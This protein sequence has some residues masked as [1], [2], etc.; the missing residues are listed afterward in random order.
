LNLRFSDRARS[1][2]RIIDELPD[3]LYQKLTDGRKLTFRSLPDP[4]DEPEDERSDTFF[5][6]LEAARRSDEEYL[7]VLEELEEEDEASA[8]GQ[9]IERALKDRV[10]QQLGLP[11]RPTRETMTPSEYARAKGI[12]PSYD[13]LHPKG[14][15]QAKPD[16]LDDFVQTLLFPD[17]MERK[18][19]GIRDGARIAL[20]EMGVNILYA[21]FGYLEWYESETS[22]LKLFAPL[23]LHPLALERTLVRQTYRYAAT[24]IDDD[25]EVNLTLKERL[26]RDFR[27]VLPDLEEKDT[28]EGYFIKVESAIKEMKRWHVRRFVTVGLFPFS[29]LVM[30]HDLDPDRWP[31]HKAL[32]LHPV[33]VELLG[34]SE[35]GEAFYADDYEVDQPEIA[36]KVPLL[37]T[38]VDASQFSAIAD[39]MD[40]KI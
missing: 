36:A 26:R 16:H 12:D 34:G 39:V 10:R 18:L 19:S 22:D 17:Q 14:K 9:R 33:V 38:D 11:P 13:L 35:R 40:G 30:Y 1:Y 23:L 32:H 27:L 25:S 24:S 5:L 7:R 3:V 6:A 2:V 20:S 31:E 29:R 15:G 4:E 37:I 8:K 28:P 21:A